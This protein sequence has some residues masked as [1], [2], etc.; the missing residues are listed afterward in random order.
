MTG[1]GASFALPD[2]H[3]WRLLGIQKAS[4]NTA[5]RVRFTINLAIIPK[6]AWQQARQSAPRWPD[7]PNP[8]TNYAPWR[9]RR[10]GLLM[11]GG[12]DH[13]WEITPRTDPERIAVSVL[14]AI[15]DYALPALTEDT[16]TNS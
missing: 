15:T 6:D 11:P 7:K 2:P 4:G 16:A 13:W 12:K 3:T 5:D 14:N 1:S 10:I 8:N 9:T